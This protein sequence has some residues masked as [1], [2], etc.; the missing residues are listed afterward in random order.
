MLL[1]FTKLF[2]DLIENIS[3][4]YFI[5]YGGSSSSKTISILQYLTLYA[6][7]NENKRITISAESIPVLKKTI[8]P[9]WKLYVMGDN[10]ED[11]RFNKQENT[12]KFSNGSIFQF[13]PADD[14]SRW[15]GMRQDIVYFDELYNIKESIY[16]QAD[17]R[18]FDKVFCSFNPTSKFWIEKHWEDEHT[19]IN[20][21]TYKDNKDEEDSYLINEMTIKALEKRINTDPN[22]H[23]VY[24]LGEWGNLEGL[25]FVEGTNWF[26]CDEI[27]KEYSK[28]RI[29]LD[30]GFSIDPSAIIDVRYSDGNIY[31]DEILY[32]KGHTNQDLMKHLDKTQIIV[33]DAAEPKSIEEIRREGFEVRESLKGKD[34]IRN[35]ILRMKDFNIYVSKNS[36]NII[37]EFRN[38]KWAVDKNN[39]Q[40]NKPID[41]FNHAID[42][43]RYSVFDMFNE[44][45]IWFV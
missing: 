6:Q 32:Q 35:G 39:E 29:G 28:R 43:I 11:K 34:S 13:I 42:A 5:F 4:R 41:N 21:S 40:L 8:I 44:Q 19:Y 18:T 45:D 20:H 1:K 31:V 38:Y 16:D 23:R 30:F 17:I 10:F 3:N 14:P 36:I 9:D 22:F 27:P 25:I 37:K 7:L 24:A 2:Y 33:A 26:L 15:H 12:Y